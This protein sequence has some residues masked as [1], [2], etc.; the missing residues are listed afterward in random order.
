MLSEA[1]LAELFKHK[2]DKPR[3]AK[4]V[5]K[6]LVNGEWV[7]VTKMGDYDFGTFI[8]NVGTTVRSRKGRTY[9]APNGS[10]KYIGNHFVAPTVTA[11]IKVK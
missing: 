2:D 10:R 1:T 11:Y 6:A 8:G 7:N 4:V 3:K 5:A 9:H